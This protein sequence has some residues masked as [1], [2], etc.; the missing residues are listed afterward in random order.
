AGGAA[1]LE[2]SGGL[3]LVE[4][5]GKVVV[6]SITFGGAAEKA[7]VDFDWELK[8]VEIEADRL[9]KEL[10]YLPAF[11]LIGGV[12]MLQRSRSP[13]SRNEEATT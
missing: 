1:R 6:D 2:K 13:R 3:K 4:Q 11:L 10:F 7:G 9:P 5:E 12:I 8:A